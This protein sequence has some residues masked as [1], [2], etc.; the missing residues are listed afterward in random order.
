MKT[1]K[2]F[3][4][5]VML[6]L[7]TI[8]LSGCSGSILNL[9]SKT[10]KTLIAEGDAAYKAG[11]Y[12]KAFKSYSIAAGT[13]DPEA[14]YKLGYNCCIKGR[15]TKVNM[16]EGMTL[17]VQS[18]ENGYTKAQLDLAACYCEGYGV[19]HDWKEA[20][21]WFRKAAEKNSENAQMNLGICY[22]QGYGVE[23]NIQTAKMWYGK[24]A[25]NGNKD[26][27]ESLKR[28]AHM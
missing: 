20:V 14:Q 24:A 7:F 5:A 3:F 16:Q 17:L 27:A 8:L 22:E 21:K 9:T 23:K 19:K 2:M 6:S 18:A 11:D 26:A 1:N 12:K 25:K 15:G 4:A 13:G 28:L 10:P